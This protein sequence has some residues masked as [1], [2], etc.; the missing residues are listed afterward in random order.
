MIYFF[1]NGD[2]YR[3]DPEE[4]PPV[5]DSYPKPISN[6]E[7]LPED[8]DDALKYK[9]GYTYFFKDG[10]YWRFDDRAFKVDKA[11]PSFP[12]QAGVW[13]FGCASRPRGRLKRSK[14]FDQEFDQDQEGDGNN[15]KLSD[16]ADVPPREGK[17]IFSLWNLIPRPF[18]GLFIPD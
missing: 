9:N 1:K 2:Y 6:W 8:I 4:R 11:N 3:F 14:C 16:R 15:W 10:N 18:R 17:G 12:R 5:R 13:W 7:G